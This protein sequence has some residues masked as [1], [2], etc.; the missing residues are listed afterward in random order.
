MNINSP[1]LSIHPAA[2]KSLSQP[3]SKTD[4]KP[5]PLSIEGVILRGREYEG[6]AGITTVESIRDALEASSGDIVLHINSPGGSASGMAEI[7]SMIMAIRASGRRVE[8]RATGLL[9]SAAYFIASAADRIVAEPSTIVG[10]I[11]TY[12]VLVDSTKMMDQFGIK[13]EVVSTGPAKGLG[14]DGAI[15]QALREDTQRTVDAFTASFKSAIIG[16]RKMNASAVDALASGETWLANDALAKGLIDEVAVFSSLTK[17]SSTPKGKPMSGLISAELADLIAADPAFATV[18]LDS[19]K[20]EGATITTI[21]Q[22]VADAKLA[23]E[24]GDLQSQVAALGAEI[25]AL[26]SERDGLKSSLEQ[27]N[28]KLAKI[29]PLAADASRD[30]GGNGDTGPTLSRSKMSDDDKV[31]YI[32]EHGRK[33]FE[34]L[35]K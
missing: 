24:R 33:A 13:L 21:K 4:A 2:A 25:T 34:A 14:A 10:S 9:A 7:H 27:A 19:A 23:K 6:Y 17:G 28:A 8:V 18:A 12:S 26:K 35:P 32:R 22:A 30:A 16:G 11:G 1:W 29:T 31:K 20:V 5:T 15:T 3:V